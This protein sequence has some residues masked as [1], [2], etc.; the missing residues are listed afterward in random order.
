[1]NGTVQL[2]PR[3]ATPV[4]VAP[5]AGRRRA[6]VSAMASDA[7][8][9]NL[10]FLQ[11]LVEELGLDVANLGPCVADDLLVA[12]CRTR[13]PDLVVLSSVNGHGYQDGLRVIGRLRRVPELAT[14]PVV[15]GGKLGIRGE[16]RA[17]TLDAL[18]AAGFDAVYDDSAAALA[19]FRRFVAARIAAG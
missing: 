18:R 14:T 7:H 13:R 11:L 8:T 9:W 4:P 1:M 10:V 19:S 3:P 12:R 2:D 15:L 5:G 6:I 16:H 17:E